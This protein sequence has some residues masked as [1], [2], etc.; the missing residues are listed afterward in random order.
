MVRLDWWKDTEN[1]DP[2][3]VKRIEALKDALGLTD[4]DMR[5]MALRIEREAELEDLNEGRGYQF[6][7][8]TL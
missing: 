7:M 4:D 1:G 6:R 3:I 2:C 8:S 5:T